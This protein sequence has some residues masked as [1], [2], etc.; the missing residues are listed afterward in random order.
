MA[1]PKTLGIDIDP[2]KVD[3]CNKNGLTCIQRDIL[4]L[5][6]T[7]QVAGTTM[8]HVLEHMPT[9]ENSHHYNPSIHPPK[10]SPAVEFSE[11]VIYEEMRACAIYEPL[12]NLH[13]Y[14]AMALLDVLKLVNSSPRLIVRCRLVTDNNRKIENDEECLSTLQDIVFGSIERHKRKLVFRNLL[15]SFKCIRQLL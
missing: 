5:Q 2:T 14:S 12:D 1:M 9:C 4:K 7:S 6:A 10:P 11:P 8:W 3:H 15:A 13:V